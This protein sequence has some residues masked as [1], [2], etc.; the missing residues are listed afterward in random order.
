[1]SFLINEDHINIYSFNRVLIKTPDFNNKELIIKLKEKFEIKNLDKLG[2]QSKKENEILLYYKKKSYSLT[3][4][5][6]FE[7]SL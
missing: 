4:L 7:K 5:E 3:P 6:K 2:F 1:M